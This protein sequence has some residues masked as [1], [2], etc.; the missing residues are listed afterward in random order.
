MTNGVPLKAGEFPQVVEL[1]LND[2]ELPAYDYFCDGV[3]ISPT[4]VITAGHCITGISLEGY[5]DYF[6]LGVFP[7]FI[8]VTVQG[9]SVKAKAVTLTPSFFEFS[10]LRSE[11][12]ALV[13]LS[14][15]VTM[16]RP[17]PLMSASELTAGTPL[18][19]VS[20]G[21]KA[22]TSLTK[23][24]RHGASTVLFLDHKASVPCAGDS[25][26]AVLANKNGQW[27]LAGVMIAEDAGGCTQERAISFLPR[28][29]F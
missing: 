16:V 4:T 23:L 22:S 29:R 21:K 2:P 6:R 5:Y 13:E 19:M 15:P 7:Y 28:V 17:V 14:A 8:N 9:Q 10:D 12:L 3:V 18:L 20:H 26:G 27:K 11:D 1:H 24:E 25:G